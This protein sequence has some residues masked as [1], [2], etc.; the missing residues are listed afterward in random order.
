MAVHDA[1]VDWDGAC[2]TDSVGCAAY[3]AWEYHVL[4]RIFDD[5]LGPLARDYVGSPWSWTALER[6]VLDEPDGAVVGRHD[7]SRRVETADGQMLAAM[8]AAGADLRATLGDPP[9]WRWGALHTATFAEQTS[10]TSGIGPLESYMNRGPVE[11]PGAA[12][13]VNNTYYRLSRGL[14]R[15]GRPRVRAGRAGRACSRSPTCRRIG[16]SSTWRDIDGA[17]IVITTGQSGNP[18]DAHYDDQIDPWRT[19]QTLPFPF[20]AAAVAAATVDDPDAPALTTSRQRRRRHRRRRDGRLDRPALPPGGLADDPDRRLRGRPSAR[21]VRR[22]DPDPAL[23]A[24]RRC[25]L[26]PLG[27]R[28]PDGLAPFGDEVG[29]QLFH[30]VGM[31][32]FARREDGFE[33]RSLATL[34]ALGIPVSRMSTDEVALAAGRR[35]ASTTWRSPR[36]SRRPGWSWPDRASLPWSGRS[37]ADGGRFELAGRAPGRGRRAPAHRRGR[38]RRDA[39]RRRHVRVRRRPMAADSCSPTCSGRSSR[40]TKQDVVFLGPAAGD[41][42]FARR[43][44]AMLGRLRRRL[45]RHPGGRRPGREDRPRPR[46]PAVRPDRRR[47]AHRPR[48]RPPGAGLRRRVR[49][50]A[51]ASAPVVETRVCQYET[52]PDTEFIL[53][54]HPE[55]DNVWIA[56]GGSGHAFKHGPVIGSYLVSTDGRG[57]G[58]ARRRSGSR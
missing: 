8:D 21:D 32:W 19:G 58:A 41:G 51:L 54:R 6:F 22:R 5:E 25:V 33:A 34:T 17:R 11:V 16:C 26:R 36:S 42:R 12:G 20:T 53:D 1:I 47:A 45:L 43:V 39:A 55:L 30:E 4:R 31:L 28:G 56:G 35:S 24:R 27:A 3:M 46:R 38:R 2:T 57:A 40:V 37:A 9:A 44:A 7:D 50:P 10:A 29:E 49:F 18:F 14:S 13:A 15:P 23:V 52:T 48:D